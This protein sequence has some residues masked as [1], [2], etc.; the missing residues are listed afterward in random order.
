MLFA[1]S[2]LS[3]ACFKSKTKVFKLRTKELERLDSSERAKLLQEFRKRDGALYRLPRT[4]VIATVP[5]KKTTKEPGAFEKFAPCFFSKGEAD[6]RTTSKAVDF[7]LQRVTFGSTGEPDPDETYV[8]LTRG[9]FFESKTLLMDYTPDLRLKKGEA[10]SKNEAL[11]FIGKAAKTGIGIAARAASV[12][13]FSDS[14]P[15][16][17]TLA[18]TRF[19]TAAR[20]KKCYDLIKSYQDEFYAEAADELTKAEREVR[21]ADAEL[22]SATTPAQKQ[23]AQQKKDKAEKKKKAAAEKKEQAKK[24]QERAAKDA[25]EM[26][27]ALR[28]ESVR[29]G[30]ANSTKAQTNRGGGGGGGGT[31]GTG[32]GTGSTTG[33]GAA[34][35]AGGAQSSTSPLLLDAG[36]LRETNPDAYDFAQAILKKRRSDRDTSDDRAL[37]ILAASIPAEVRRKKLEEEK[38]TQALLD[39]LNAA[40]TG[41][42]IYSPADLPDVSLSTETLALIAENPQG[43]RLVQLNRLLLEQAFPSY[44][45]PRAPSPGGVSYSRQSLIDDYD[46]AERTFGK[47]EELLTR[48][49]QLRS[50]TSNIPPDTFKLELEK[51]DAAIG[52]YREA[53]LGEVTEE[54]WEGS[55]N[56][57]PRKNEPAQLSPV[58]FLLSPTKG[59]CTER[60]LIKEQG[61]RVSGKFVDGDCSTHDADQKDR[62]AVWLRLDRKS[63]EDANLRSNL[64]F[65]NDSYNEKEKERGWYYRIPA[66]GTVVLKTGTL[67]PSYIDKLAET[68]AASVDSTEGGAKAREAGRGEMAVAQLGVIAS[69]PASSGGRTTQSSV[70]LDEATGALLNFKVSSDALLQKT[71]LDDAK[72]ASDSIIDAADPLKRLKRENDLLDAKKDNR[73]K[74]KALENSDSNS[75]SSSNNNQ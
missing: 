62:V 43:D 68:A 72:E 63:N 69:V 73:E 29:T 28:E 12:L 67:N 36:S 55:F 14:P 54:S 4:V 2:L 57:R 38:G 75:N 5:V 17:A 25:E 18:A 64:G 59:I 52:A 35:G 34:S 19:A 41:R 45:R 20:A 31:G 10:E 53:F 24:L 11:E 66:P 26:A 70:V 50:S 71:L 46:R 37:S 56:F 61:V 44:V 51:T 32:G 65:V 60:G 7:A 16:A 48:Q 58:L 47:L 6:D 15:D 3:S 40:L 30:A 13:A 1:L 23:L 42:M 21:D 49:D 27:K 39:A 9:G 22:A 74:R 33:G 8:V